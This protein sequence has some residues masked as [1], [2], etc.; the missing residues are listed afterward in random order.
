MF[1]PSAVTSDIL[2]IGTRNAEDKRKQ[3][4]GLCPS[5]FLGEPAAFDLPNVSDV[6]AVRVNE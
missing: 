2:D 3:A 6:S 5:K 4:M 1:G